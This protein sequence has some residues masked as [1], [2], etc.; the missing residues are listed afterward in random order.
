MSCREGGRARKPK[1][2]KVPQVAYAR[3]L[4]PPPLD[5]QA[6][7]VWRYALILHCGGGG[8][9][10]A[11][12]PRDGH[13]PA[14]ASVRTSIVDEAAQGPPS[15]QPGGPSNPTAPDGLAPQHGPRGA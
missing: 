10:I 7:P 8:A 12:S 2:L 14:R 6:L 3:E 1:R 9:Q 4:K 15:A 11:L 13:W 5:T